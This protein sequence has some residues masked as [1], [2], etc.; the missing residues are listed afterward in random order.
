MI[1]VTIE[2]NNMIVSGT[3][4]NADQAADWLANTLRYLVS[5]YGIT[6]A[7]RINI[8]RVA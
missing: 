2:F 8:R 6:I 5:E 3:F 7:T 1:S 4:V